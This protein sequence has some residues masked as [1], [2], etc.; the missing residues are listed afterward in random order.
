MNHEM[1]FSLPS[2]FLAIAGIGI[3]VVSFISL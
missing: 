1:C 3:M 2:A